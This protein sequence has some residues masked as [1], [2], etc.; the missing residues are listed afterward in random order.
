MR[1]TPLT[2]IHRGSAHSAPRT[3]TWDRAA[4]KWRQKYRF[5]HESRCTAMCLD[6]TVGAL[7]ASTS[8]WGNPRPG[9]GRGHARGER[10]DAS[11]ERD[12]LP[13][14]HSSKTTRSS[15]QRRAQL[16]AAA[17]R[18]CRRSYAPPLT[19]R[20]S[21]SGPCGPASPCATLSQSRPELSVA[22]RHCAP[23]FGGLIG[24]SGFPAAMRAVSNRGG[25]RCS[26][27]RRPVAAHMMAIRIAHGS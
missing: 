6:H 25:A 16:V 8:T 19:V 23:I 22:S 12:L 27:R 3:P 15:W 5:V 18:R 13:W 2:A 24:I 20:R 14:R 21:R 17:R 1:L 26:R 4:G 7:S 10:T 11:A 9:R